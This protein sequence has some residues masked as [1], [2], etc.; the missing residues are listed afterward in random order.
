MKISA[1]NT[2]KI[3]RVWLATKA[4]ESKN[5]NMESRIQKLDSKL[6]QML[7]W[8]NVCTLL[9]CVQTVFTVA[10]IYSNFKGKYPILLVLTLV[11]IVLLFAV[12][13]YFKWKNIAY[14]DTGFT[15]ASKIH[16]NYYI[17]K[18]N[19]QCKQI[20]GYLLI[21][22][23]TLILSGFFFWRGIYD[24]LTLLFKA[25]ALLSFVIYGLGFYFMINFTKQK[26]KL[27]L[28]EAQVNPLGFM[29][30]VVQN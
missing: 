20:S 28:L 3:K 18:L 9:A 7:L 12:F 6:Q 22:A 8:S 4:D 29:E 1:T 16:L 27:K 11:I 13:L 30:N 25:T 23:L 17:I 26:N 21:Y 10:R 19:G 15:K 2:H 24:G 5:E 14:K